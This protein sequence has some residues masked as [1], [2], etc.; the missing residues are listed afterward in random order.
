MSDHLR[1]DRSQD[2]DRFAGHEV[3]E[4]LAHRARLRRRRQSW[5]A[6]IVVKTVPTRLFCAAERTSWGPPSSRVAS[7][8][9]GLPDGRSPARPLAWF[10]GAD[11]DPADVSGVLLGLFGERDPVA[12]SELVWDSW[13]G[14]G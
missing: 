8:C 6:G 14:A 3:N 11:S 9:G 1:A 5:G 13:P 4:M 12:L 7:A 2:I 10:C